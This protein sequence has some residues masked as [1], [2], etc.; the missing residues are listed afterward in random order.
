MVMLGGAGT[1]VGP[2]VGGAIIG[3]LPVVL[4]NYPSVSQY[5]YGGLLIA[6][7]RLLPRGIVTK[8]GAPVPRRARKAAGRRA[9]PRS[10][11]E[12]LVTASVSPAVERQSGGL[13][14]RGLKRHFGN[15]YAVDDVSFELAPGES[16]A[17]VGP[18]GSGKTTMINLIA[19]QYH[20]HGGEVVLSGRAITGMPPFRVARLG[21]SR[22][23]QVPQLFP[24]LTGEEHLALA[25]RYAVPGRDESYEPIVQRLLADVGLAGKQLTREARTFSHGQQR[26]LETCMAVLRR[27][28]VLLLDEPAAGLAESEIQLLAQLVREVSATGT[29]V[30]VV[31]HHIDFVYQVADR[32]LVM[33]LGHAIWSGSPE[34]FKTSDEVREAYLGVE[35][36]GST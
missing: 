20:P 18:N 9:L 11:D 28:Q 12:G 15:V 7:V 36:V 35:I 5:I 13:V 33:H 1:R 17:V 31:E 10:S 19:G 34:G 24:D 16:L 25:R 4:A 8:R 21:V 3:L 22:T 23:F 2:I 29:G 14:I 6:T 27:P 32:I 30:I 26:F